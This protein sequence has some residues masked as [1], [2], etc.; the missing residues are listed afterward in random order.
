TQKNRA[1]IEKGVSF[2]VNA[3]ETAP[4]GPRLNTPQGTQPQYKM[5]ELVDTHFAALMLGEV[6]GKLS[7]ELNR[8]VAIWYD[9]VLSKVQMTQNTDGS[10]DSNGWAPVLSSSIAAQSLY[11]A[12]VKGKDISDDVLDRSDAYQAGLTGGGSGSFDASE[13]AGVELYAVASGLRGNDQTRKRE[14]A[15]GSS[16]SPTAEVAEASADAAASRVAADADG[17]LVAGFGS[18]GGEE[19][20]SY[21]LISDT[22]AENGGETWEP[23]HHQHGVRHRGSSDDPGGWRCRGVA[24]GPC[25]RLCE[26]VR[27]LPALKSPARRS[28]P[29]PGGRRFS[30]RPPA[31]LVSRWRERNVTSAR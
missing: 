30:K 22:L 7:P 29:R 8:K 17:R 4:E 3:V 14:Q 10:F 1:A 2:V 15:T 5:G 16:S 6:D 31:V 18:I 11:T 12:K 9:M 26:R 21:Q 13:G 28:G 20:L 24:R 23:L 27:N 19:M 25:R